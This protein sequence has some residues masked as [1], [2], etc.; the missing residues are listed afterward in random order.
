MSSGPPAHARVGG[1]L[2]RLRLKCCRRRPVHLR[3]NTEEKGRIAGGRAR[4]PLHTP[5]ALSPAQRAHWAHPRRP[6]QLVGAPGDVPQHNGSS[7]PWLTD[8][9]A[10]HSAQPC[11][12]GA[13]AGERQ[14]RPATSCGGP[15]PGAHHGGSAA[16]SA[17][18]AASSCSFMFVVELQTS[19]VNV[20]LL[21]ASACGV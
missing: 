13:G 8:V 1:A 11:R 2:C 9:V 12:H 18:G 3:P 14:L 7:C 17:L 6:L 4:Q 16:V 21:V 15:L 20:E 19:G 5:H 10:G